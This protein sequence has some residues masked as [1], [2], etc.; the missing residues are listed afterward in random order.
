VALA[1]VFVT[2]EL[3]GRGLILLY[4]RLPF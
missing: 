1:L 3:A 2:G 4:A